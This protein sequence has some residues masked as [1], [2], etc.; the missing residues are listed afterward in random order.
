MK[1]VMT[2]AALWIILG[3]FFDVNFMDIFITSVVLTVVGFIGDLFV[4][5]RIGNVLAAIADFF[6][7]LV[8]VWLLGANI[9]DE[10]IALGTAAFI[11]A[12]I[13]MMGELFLHRYMASH[14]FEPQKKDPDT[15]IGYYQRTDLLTEFAEEMD[16]DKVSKE[17]KK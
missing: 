17:K 8:V 9:F 5:P 4:L 15:K 16:I 11:C 3:V 7:A 1:F 12:L 2:T 13:I 14:I 6:L 10:P